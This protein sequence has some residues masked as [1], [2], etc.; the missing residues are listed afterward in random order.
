MDWTKQKRR[1]FYIYYGAAC[2]ELVSLYVT[3]ES[4][5]Y[6]ILQSLVGLEQEK[7][8]QS[9]REMFYALGG[10]LMVTTPWTILQEYV[11]SP[12]IH[13]KVKKQ[14]SHQ[15]VLFFIQSSP[16]FEVLTDTEMANLT[17]YVCE[18]IDLNDA[19]FIG[20]EEEDEDVLDMEQLKQILLEYAERYYQKYPENFMVLSSIIWRDLFEENK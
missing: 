8:R 19:P 14:H 3:T 16:L 2:L 6:H 13:K 9:V 17:L 11:Y 20:K 1:D 4:L 5:E 18:G 15:H 10:K 7:F 12:D